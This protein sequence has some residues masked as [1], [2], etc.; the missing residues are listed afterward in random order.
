MNDYIAVNNWDKWQSYRKD[1]GT[2]PWIKIHRNLMSNPEWSML[3]DAEKGQLVSIW[4]VAA[5]KKGRI[6]SCPSI[7][8][9]MCLLD[10]MPNINKF[11]ELGF[12]TTACQPSDNQVTTSCPQHDAPETETETETE[13]DK[14]SNDFDRWWFAY[15][16]KKGKKKAK[17]IWKVIKP[18]ADVLI[19][20][21]EDRLKNDRQWKKGF[22]VNPT[23]YLNEERW[24][25]QI[26]PDEKKTDTDDWQKELEQ[27]S[28]NAIK[29]GQ[30]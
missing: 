17:E 12:L 18:D 9:K 16:V 29:A 1:R 27:L 25:D 30:A 28:V 19:A 4:V 3:T 24:N 2:P 8:K 5:D 26:T 15:P 6:S 22:I 13:T 10:R 7:I 23:K 14:R 11:I 21:V 20:D